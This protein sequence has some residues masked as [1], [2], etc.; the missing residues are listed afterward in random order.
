MTAAALAAITVTST[1]LLVYGLNLLYLSVRAARLRPAAE[2]H[3]LPDPLP[4]VLVQLP[5]YDER[6]V[7]ARVIEAAGALDWPRARLSIQVLDDSDDDTTE[8]AGA[9]VAG[10]RARGIDASHVRREARRGYKAGALADGLR[11]SHSELVAVF[12]ADFVPPPDF[13]RRAVPSFAD[14]RV[15]F[16]QARW[17]HLNE[18]HSLFTRMQALVIDFHYLVEQVVR[19]RLG[20]PTNFTGSAGLWRR[21]AIDDAGGWRAD[22]LTEDLDLSYRAQVRG[23]TAVF[24]EDLVVPQ[25]LPVSV[26]A[27][28]AQQTRWATGSFQCA[29]RLLRPL[30]ESP[31]PRFAKF[32]GTMHLLGYAAPLAMLT[33]LVAYAALLASDLH[34]APALTWWL[35]AS[36]LSLA[37]TVGIS[38]AQARRGRRWWAQLPAGLGW[39]LI[40]LGT[41]L[42]VATAVWR[43]ARGGGEFRRTPKFA[44]RT[45]GRERHAWRASSYFL[46]QDAFAWVELA[47]GLTTVAVLL[48]ALSA[49]RW[50]M[51]AYALLFAAGFLTMGLGSF[52]QAVIV[53]RSFALTAAVFAAC[54]AVLFVFAGQPDPFEDSY[55]H[56]LIAANLATSGHLND[57][58]FQMQDTWL[59]AYEVLAAGVLKVAGTWQ[60]GAL[61]L[62]SAALGL[63]TLGLTYAL[64]GS[65]RRGLLAVLLL[66]L[67][68]A[69]VLTSTTAVS[70]P[71]LVT[72]LL[73]SV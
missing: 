58:L 34:P 12:D 29:R 70:E 31:L 43:A 4:A 35:A 5:I 39:T 42:T 32:Q 71:L 63:L 48:A 21:A 22:T 36:L 60:L 61:K 15:G 17:G 54:G 19:A 62:L 64:A 11:R 49:Q 59:P 45:G 16:V 68:P 72:A 52:A 9:A 18:T 25:E 55:Q 30:L 24:L 53:I 37:P 69:F 73:G 14:R 51:A 33:Q 47:A 46:P 3:T 56:W 27:Y 38:V 44:I 67:N 6:H 13:L 10:L 41:S 8:L 40:G 50:V 2:S 66:G 20:Y 26:N 57:P 7:A 1:F 23:W 65:R 28:R